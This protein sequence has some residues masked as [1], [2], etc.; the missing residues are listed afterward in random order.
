M[1]EVFVLFERARFRFRDLH[2]PPMQQLHVLGRLDPAELHEGAA[3][4]DAHRFDGR[5][6]GLLFVGGDERHRVE[7]VEALERIGPRLDAGLAADAVRLAD[8]A[9]GNALS[10]RCPAR[11]GGASSGS[12][13]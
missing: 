11:S 12:P 2:R 1:E 3:G 4:V 6:A 9:D 13:R 10:Q 7:R 5:L 8:H